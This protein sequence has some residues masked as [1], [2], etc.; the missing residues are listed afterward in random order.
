MNKNRIPIILFAV[1]GAFL[2]IYFFMSG[3]DEKNYQWFESYDSKS[4]QPYGTLFIKRLL[5]SYRPEGTFV[6]NDKKSLK[7]LLDSTSANLN[8]DYI[9]IGQSI[10]LNDEDKD[11]LVKFVD[12][13]NDAFISSLAAPVDIIDRF[14]LNE[15]EEGLYFTNAEDDSTINVTFNFYHDTLRTQGG[16][17]YSYRYGSVDLPY[18]WMHLTNRVFCENTT[19]IIPLG[20]RTPDLVNFFKLPHGKGNLYI[21]CNPLVFTNYFLT[22]KDKAAYA[23]GVFTHLNG[24]NMIWDEYSKIPFWDN[25]NAYNSPLYYILQQPS[26][27]YAWW[28]LLLTVAIYVLFAAK[29]TQ[30]IIPVFEPKTNTSLEFVNLISSLHYLNG[31]HLDMV[32]KKMKYFLYFIRSKYGIHAQTFSEGD[33]QKLSDKSKVNLGDVQAIFNQYSLI[34]RNFANDIEATRLVDFYYAIEKFYKTCK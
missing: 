29:R 9:F 4:D 26:L 28:L 7:E 14:Y 18:E 34:E 5:E 17:S 23:S 20:Y 13:G 22:K 30:R 33:I 3:R 1:L 15:C 24:K 25:N 19:S 11:A 32:K 16:Y 10:H 2:L 12:A 21:H 31:N 27:K 8:T 6:S